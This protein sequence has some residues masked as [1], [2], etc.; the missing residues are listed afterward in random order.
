MTDY[1]YCTTQNGIRICSNIPL[2]QQ[3]TP[4]SQY[5]ITV[6]TSIPLIAVF[7]LTGISGVAA[8]YTLTSQQNFEAQLKKQGYTG[9]ITNYKVEIPSLLDSK[10]YIKFTASSPLPQL[11]AIAIIMLLAV[12]GLYIIYMI[13]DVVLGPASG[14]PGGGI[15]GT[16]IRIGLGIAL[17]GGGLLGLYYLYKKASKGENIYIP[18]PQIPTSKQEKK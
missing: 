16:A 7:A 12:I 6:N 2:N 10:F 11:V 15:G 17:I 18:I 13:V 9:N 3:P 14:A 5:T 1:P 4:G 8:F